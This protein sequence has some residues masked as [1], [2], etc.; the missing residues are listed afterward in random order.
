MKNS[1]QSYATSFDRH[2]TDDSLLGHAQ[3]CEHIAGICADEQ[4]AK[5]FRN[6]AR[7]CRDA[8]ARDWLPSGC[9]DLVARIAAAAVSP[10]K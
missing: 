10:N 2:E 4:S 8:A 1:A 3:L 6:L 5:R 9:Q 7:Q